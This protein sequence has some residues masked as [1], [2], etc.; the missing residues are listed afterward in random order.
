MGGP[1][2]GPRAGSG[3][4]GRGAYKGK[5]VGKKLTYPLPKDPRQMPRHTVE[6][7]IKMLQ[8]KFPYMSKHEAA[9]KVSEFYNKHYGGK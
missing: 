4:R 8:K 7:S 5:A 3:K 9:V 2:S 6:Q 1:G